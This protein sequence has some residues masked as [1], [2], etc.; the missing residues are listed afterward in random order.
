MRIGILGAGLSGVSLAYFLQDHEKI[1]SIELL[2]KEQEIG[3]LCRSFELNGVYYDIGP[4][5]I[6][7]KDEEILELMVKLLGNN[8][9]KF[10]RSNRIYCKGNFVKYPFENELSAL[11]EKDKLYCLNSFLNNPYETYK[12]QNMIQ[13]FLATFGEG[14][15]NVYLRPYNEKIWKFDPAFMDT[16]MVERIPKPP[17]EDIIKSAGGV[18]TEGY[19]HQLY[20]YYPRKEGIASLVKAFENKL[21]WKVRIVTDLDIV[22]INKIKNQ[23]IVKSLS[24]FDKK[25]DLVISTIPL[26]VLTKALGSIVP[27]RVR[28]AVN[29]LKYNS[30]VICALNIDKDCLGDNFAIMIPDKEIIFHR[31]S[32]INFLNQNPDVKSSSTTLL[33]EITYRKGGLIDDM[34]DI[35]IENRVLRDLEKLKFIDKEESKLSFDVKRFEYSYI[36][37]DLNYNRNIKIINDFYNNEL[38]IILCGRFGEFRYLNMDA[39]IRNS[40]DKSNYIK[41]VL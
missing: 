4:H 16:Q 32:K 6:F 35:E 26:T 38:Q 24:K 19:L 10:K 22:D 9:N 27:D 8:I 18:P 21:D 23:W 5:I 29:G 11:P 41:E 13:F 15:T 37:Y 31:L 14:I 1:S 12:P 30:I 28:E 2:E 25:Y 20:F 40:L 33:A 3:G 34:S 36:I 39:V 17:K 7:S